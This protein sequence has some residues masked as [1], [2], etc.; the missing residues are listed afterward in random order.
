MLPIASQA[1]VTTSLKDG[2]VAYW[3]L[4]ESKGKRADATGHGNDLTNPGMVTRGNGIIRSAAQ[5]TAANNQYLIHPDNATL[6]TGNINFTVSGWMWLDSKSDN[7]VL[8]G[9]WKATGS[10]NKEYI[11]MYATDHDRF[12]FSLSPDSVTQVDLQANNLGSPTTGKWYFVVAWYDAS[13]KTMNL[14]VNNGAVDSASYTLGLN[15]TTADFLLG[16]NQGVPLGNQHMDGRIDEVGFWKRI[17]SPAERAT[18]YNNG[19][20]LTYPFS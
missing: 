20:G 19:K 2:L 3:K 15:D 6:S 9:K 14:Q 13:A 12:Q 5:L 8:A 11:L 4:D 10:G 17:L 18:L 1:Q 16:H 7:R